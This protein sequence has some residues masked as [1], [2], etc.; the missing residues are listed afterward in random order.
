[1]PKLTRAGGRARACHR[2]RQINVSIR[3]LRLSL[4]QSTGKENITRTRPLRISKN[5]PCVHACGN[6]GLLHSDEL[7]C[8]TG[9]NLPLASR[10]SRPQLW[11]HAQ[12]F[13]DGATRG[14]SAFRRHPQLSTDN[15][16]SLQA[17]PVPPTP[18]L[19]HLAHDRHRRDLHHSHGVRIHVGTATT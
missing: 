5:P 7:A 10:A 4:N 19:P 11:K 13:A 9:L 2:A 18:R 1:M 3:A 16:N 6:M 14:K 12:G 8:H 17:P 15:K